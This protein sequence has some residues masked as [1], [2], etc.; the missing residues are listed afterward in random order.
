MTTTLPPTIVEIAPSYRIPLVLL[1]LG[2]LTIPLSLWVAAPV[3]F[4]S[5]FLTLQTATIRL[6]FTPQSLE[7]YRSGTQIRDFPY[8]DW[9]NWRVFWPG[10][11]IL[12]YFREVKSIHFLPMLFNSQELLAC[13]APLP[14]VD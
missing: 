1:G 14:K 9:Q 12:F 13:L 10:F 7:V 11:P 8:R 4:F 5:L 6:R 2:L 3:I